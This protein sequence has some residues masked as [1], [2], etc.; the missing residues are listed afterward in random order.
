MVMLPYYL[1]TVATLSLVFQKCTKSYI[2]TIRQILHS[3]LVVN[4]LS[5]SLTTVCYA[6]I[7]YA[8]IRV[9]TNFRCAVQHSIVRCNVCVVRCNIL[10][11]IHC[12]VQHTSQYV[13]CSATYQVVSVLQCNIFLGSGRGSR[14]CLLYVQCTKT[15]SNS[16]LGHAKKPQEAAV[17]PRLVSRLRTHQITRQGHHRRLL[18]LYKSYLTYK[19]PQ[20][21]GTF[22]RIYLVL[23]YVL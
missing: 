4:A 10:G 19:L 7:S 21:S 6:T 16:F 15:F 1:Y 2:V 14:G 5:I 9:L 23:S 12:A 17:R 8:T 20:K 22:L 13:L 11:S 3:M 18:E